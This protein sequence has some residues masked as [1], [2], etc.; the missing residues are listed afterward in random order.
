MGFAG[1]QALI[2][3][4]SSGIGKATAHL[5]AAVGAHIHILGRDQAKIDAA[6]DELRAAA[7]RPDDPM[8]SGSSVDVSHYDQV[9]RA[10]QELVDAGRTPDYLFN[11]AGVARPGCFHELPLSV[12]RETMEINFFGTLHTTKAVAPLMMARGSGHIINTSSVAGFLGVFGY[13]AYGASKWAIRGFTDV[14]RSELKPYGVKVSILFPPDT[15]TPQ[16]WEENKTKPSE[17][18]AL[19]GNVRVVSPEA[20][21]G[22]LLRNVERGRYIIIPGG[23]SKLVYTLAG[24]FGGKMHLLFDRI[25]QRAQRANGGA[26][27]VYQDILGDRQ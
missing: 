27:A 17:T 3:G 18:R 16:L 8:I 6:L 12:F 22:I 2:T 4:G 10:V 20:V 13:T 19:A 5:L 7:G 26:P 15:D 21:A 9:T 23:E 25:I 24:L 1:S 14:L 11:F